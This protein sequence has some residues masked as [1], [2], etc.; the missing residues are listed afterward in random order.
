MIRVVTAG[1]LHA[2]EMADILNAIIKKGGTT[3]YTREL[4]A[5]DLKARMAANPERSVWHIAE[6]TEGEVVGF[7]WIT[8][9]DYL[10]DEAAEIATF[11]KLGKV[12]LG[13]GSALFKKTKTAARQMGYRWIN[14]NIRAD[15]ESGLTY[16]RSRGF[17][18]YATQPNIRLDS[19]QIVDKTLNRYDL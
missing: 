4:T 15:N 3:A 13:I 7:Q 9:A 2:R 14:A 19:G 1:A 18:Q 16:Y 6:T 5:S 8:S 11:V 12:G 17:E 10:P